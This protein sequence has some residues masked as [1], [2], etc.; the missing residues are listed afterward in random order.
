MSFDVTAIAGTDSD[1]ETV[2]VYVDDAPSPTLSVSIVGTNDPV[3]A[4]D[5]LTVTADVYN[6]GGTHT[7]GTAR[8]LVGDDR[9]EVDAESVSLAGGA[10]SRVRLGYE[11][12]PVRQDV[13]FPVVVST[14]DDEAHR[15]VHVTGMG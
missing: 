5:F 3:A 11:T 12:Y 13:S 15:T 7:S 8:L 4:G 9:E 2:E 6:S 1:T 10:S 14:G